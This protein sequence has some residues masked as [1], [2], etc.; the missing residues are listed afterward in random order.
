MSEKN[1]SDKL[2]RVI[3][4]PL[5]SASGNVH[6]ML[7]MSFF[8]VFCTEALKMNPI[9][10]GF[11]MMGS[12]MFNALTDPIVGAL[13]D[14]TETKFGKFRPF[15]VS[16]AV[17]MNICIILLFK[18]SFIVPQNALVAWIIVSYILWDIGYSMMSAVNKSA[19][20][21]VTKNPKHRPVS[22]IAGGV[23]STLLYTVILVG[24]A[25]FLKQ[26]GGFGSQTGW[27]MI[28]IFAIILNVVL[29][30][31]ALVAIS[32][33]DK[34]EFFTTANGSKEKVK[35]KDYLQV[36]RHN[37]PLQM[38]MLSAGSNKLADTVDS[39]CLIYFYM[40]AV[41]NMSIQPM[42]SGF[43]TVVSFMGAF[44]A[45]GIAIRYGL[46]KTF[47][48]GAWINLIISGSLLIIQPF[49][50]NLISVF[51]VLMS[52]NM[53]CR[54]MTA[55]NVDPMIAEIIDY[56]TYK[57]G[58][59][60]PGTI[61]SLFAFVDKCLSSS[62]GAIV[63]TVMSFAGYSAGAKPTEILFWTTLLLYLLTPLLGDLVSV[64]AMKFYKIDK[65][66]YKEMYV[67]NGTKEEAVVK[68]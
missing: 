7:F 9:V 20:S 59:F 5:G 49:S 10:T 21:I 60:M 54:R 15:L 8:M 2:W 39:A 44:V 42:V 33:K 1:A 58:K 12:R 37:K 3:L 63:G 46:K 53:L 43:S 47:V 62:A 65:N 13:L 48:L 4:F 40:Y 16:G 24:I 56:H 29:L 68:V 32:A 23:Y 34:P 52:L 27:S 61:G 26:H 31:L 55:Q 19:L 30:L 22:G 38:L 28:A 11:I 50:E 51:I 57:T 67:D 45:G 14:K 41:Q 66:L 6:F 17:I 18:I 35:F 25:P 36:V 64:I